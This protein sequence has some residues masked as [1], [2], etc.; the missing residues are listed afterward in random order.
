MI[1]DV[2]LLFE[3]SVLAKQYLECIH[4]EKPRY[5]RDQLIILRQTLNCTDKH[6][7]SN[8]LHHCVDMQIYSAN[9]FRSV[10]DSYLKKQA[11]KETCN[12]NPISANPLSGTMLGTAHYQPRKSSISDYDHLMRGAN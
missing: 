2:S 6:L 10:A 3:D 5:I 9:D 4:R 7:I 8:T 11:H 12:I 1:S